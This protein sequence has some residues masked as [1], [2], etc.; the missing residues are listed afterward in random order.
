MLLDVAL[1]LAYLHSCSILH[2]DIKPANVLL[3]PDWEAKL[4]DCG[5]ARRLRSS[6]ITGE[7]DHR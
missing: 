5:S 1:G 2:S 3:G 4:A 7:P 6:L